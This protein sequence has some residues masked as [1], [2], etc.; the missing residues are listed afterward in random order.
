MA[1]PLDALTRA[2]IRY[3]S[4]KYGGHLYTPIYNRLFAHRREEPLKLLEIGV[5]GYAVER[6]GGL[7]LK[8]WAEYFP[9]ASI[10]G[11]DVQPKNLILSPRIRVVQGSQ[12]DRS[13][14]EAMSADRGPFDIVIDDGSHHVEHMMSTFMFLYP[15]MAADGVYAIEDTQTSFMP[16]MGGR[17]DGADT[18]FD[19]AHKV[20]LAMHRLEGYVDPAADAA[21]A[22]IAAMTESVSVYR[23]IVVFQRGRN[24]YP[25]NHG[26]DLSNPE[27]RDVFEGIAAQD[28][29]DPS[30]TGVLSRV[31]MLIWA[32]RM[33][34]AG[35]LA[36]R[37]AHA[38]PREK[39]LL[40]ELS[41]M[42]EW[43]RLDQQQNDIN[44]LLINLV[45]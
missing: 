31:D 5:G 18:V 29:S 9:M 43:A 44:R 38:Y 27:V 28:A 34:E 25:S 19:M 23:N 13:V 15:K 45:G 32:G 42:M 8:M 3:G 40:F 14:L 24:T 37:A 4:D 16:G 21:V 39:P 33:E 30:P 17:S 11:L 26:L 7:G 12:T 20:S 36:I 22:A 1:K 41:R 6:A 2:A 10:T 35:A